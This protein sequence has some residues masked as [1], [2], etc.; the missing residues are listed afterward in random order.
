MGIAGWRDRLAQA[1]G[2]SG[3]T[4]NAISLESGNANNYVH[5]ILKL[6]KDPSVERLARVCD[7]A[8]VSLAYVLLGTDLS[9]DDVRLIQSLHNRP[10]AR[11]AIEVL[12]LA[13]RPRDGGG[14]LSSS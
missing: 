9:S 7:A 12:L 14:G 5:G 1:V 11:A 8:N 4:P 2:R 13:A 3:K 10:D 6:R